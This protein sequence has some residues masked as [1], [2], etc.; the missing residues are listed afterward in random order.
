M[1]A[2]RDH[3][4]SVVQKVYRNDGAGA[5]KVPGRPGQYGAQGLQ[6]PQGEPGNDGAQGIQGPQG[7]PGTSLWVDGDEAVS[8]EA[9]VRIGA[10]GQRA[11]FPWNV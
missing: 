6:G 1:M 8:T 7:D 3:R 10:D 5:P 9:N 11:E 4:G 2:P